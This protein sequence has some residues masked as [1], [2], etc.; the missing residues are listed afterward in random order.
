[1]ELVDKL[2]IQDLE[3][4]V[5]E[6]SY[7][8]GICDAFGSYQ[9][10]NKDAQII[11]FFLATEDRTKRYIEIVDKFTA[12]GWGVSTIENHLRHLK[13][14]GI[15][16]K[17]DLPGEYRLEYDM[18]EDVDTLLHYLLGDLYRLGKTSWGSKDYRF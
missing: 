11:M 4:K 18:A 16:T 3:K 10:L 1:M 12:R 7:I 14:K 13:E 2:K 9:A 15:L 6:L 5:E 8:H 17:G